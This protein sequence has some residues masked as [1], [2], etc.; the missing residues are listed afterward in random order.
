MAK[1]NVNPNNLS[2]LKLSATA[3]EIPQADMVSG[4][5]R[6]MRIEGVEDSF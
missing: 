4:L 6:D 5:Q 1:N 3:C 2:L